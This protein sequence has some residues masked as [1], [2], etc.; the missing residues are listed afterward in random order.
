MKIVVINLG[1]ANVTI[2]D[3]DRIAQLVLCPVFQA[4]FEEV[5]ALGDTARGEGGFGSTGR[6]E[7]PPVTGS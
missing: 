7:A 4:Q 2:R 5:T 3:Q 1:R 6:G